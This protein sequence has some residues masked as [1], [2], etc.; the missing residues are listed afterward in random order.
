MMIRAL[1]AS[2]PAPETIS[3]PVPIWIADRPRV[4]AVPKRV[5]M[6]AMMSTRR[7]AKP[8]VWFSPNSVRNTEDSRETRPRR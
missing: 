4:A 6:I 1:L 5:A 8:L 3:T 2:G 7:P